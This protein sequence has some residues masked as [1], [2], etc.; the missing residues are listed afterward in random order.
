MGMRKSS[1]LTQGKLKPHSQVV[2]T[3]L[4]DG[5]GVLLHLTTKFFFSLNPTSTFLWKLLAKGK[6]TRD[7]LVKRLV[8][9][10]NVS[11]VRAQR[12]VDRFLTYLL[13]EELLVP[14]DKGR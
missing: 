11:K 7:G 8:R 9:G 13:N 4:A 10:Y 1:P 12:D 3:E 5:T 2:F 6:I 14:P